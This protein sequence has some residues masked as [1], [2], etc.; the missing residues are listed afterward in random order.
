VTR[1]RE[2]GAWDVILF[3]NTAMYLRPDVADGV[4]EELE[5]SLRLG[6]VLVVGK[7]ERPT[8]ARRLAAIGPSVYRR[9]RAGSPPP[10]TARRRDPRS[11]WSPCARWSR[12]PSSS[13]M[14]RR[15]RT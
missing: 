1:T 14:R 2:P 3:R 5:R 7:A 13:R 9:I 11:R 15:R 4:W 12:A 8:S 10:R 6:G